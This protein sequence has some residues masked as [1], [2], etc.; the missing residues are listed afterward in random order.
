MLKL[1]II[2]KCA[3]WVVACF[4]GLSAEYDL[5]VAMPFS[6]CALVDDANS[7][8]VPLVA[9]KQSIGRSRQTR[10]KDTRCSKKQGR[11]LFLLHKKLFF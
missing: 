7:L 6:S 11:N 8:D 3:D 1:S 2:W 9:G 10:I 5:P 4:Q